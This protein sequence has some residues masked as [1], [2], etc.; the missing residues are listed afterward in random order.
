[1][2][3][4]TEPITAQPYKANNNFEQF[5]NFMPNLL[6][7]LNNPKIVQF[8]DTEDDKTKKCEQC[9]FYLMIDSGYGYCRRFPPQ[10][11]L[12]KKKLKIEYPI[13]EWHRV[14]CGEFL[15]R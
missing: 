1:M 14:R 5:V 3:I 6:E 8:I 15:D 7:I 9:K 10:Q 11:L 12:A 2:Q 4:G 13:T